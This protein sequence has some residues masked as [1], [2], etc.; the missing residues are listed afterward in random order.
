MDRQKLIDYLVEHKDPHS[1]LSDVQIRES[2]E[3]LSD[4]RLQQMTDAMNMKGPDR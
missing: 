3:K 2:L 4:E 1:P